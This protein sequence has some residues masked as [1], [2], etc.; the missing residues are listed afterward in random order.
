MVFAAALAPAVGLVAPNLGSGLLTFGA[1]TV[2]AVSS[3]FL[4]A[5]TDVNNFGFSATVSVH[6][7]TRSGTEEQTYLGSPYLTYTDTARIPQSVECSADLTSVSGDT[8]TG[9]ILCPVTNNDIGTGTA[10]I[11]FNGAS[12]LYGI[13]VGATST[14]LVETLT[15]TDAVPGQT[16]YLS[17]VTDTT[18]ETTT[19]TTKTITLRGDL[20]TSYCLASTTTTMTSPTTESTTKP[21]TRTTSTKSAP[22][23]TTSSKAAPTRTTSSKAAPT[24]TTSPKSPPATTSPPS[25]KCT[26]DNLYQT[27]ANHDGIAKHFCT[28]LLSEKHEGFPASIS[29]WPAATISSACS[30]YDKNIIGKR[31]TV[32]YDALTAYPVPAAS[33]SYV[34]TDTIIV[35]VDKIVSTSKAVVD[36]GTFTATASSTST[37]DLR[38]APTTCVPS[39]TLSKRTS[40]SS[41]SS[42]P[43]LK[44]QTAYLY[45]EMS[46]PVRFC[47]YYLSAKRTRSPLLSVNAKDLT[48]TCTCVVKD[49]GQHAT[50][51]QNDLANF[52]TEAASGCNQQYARAVNG[53]FRQSKN[54]CIYWGSNVSRGLTPIPGVSAAGIYSGCQ[55]I[56][57]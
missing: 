55:C 3:Y 4:A 53:F 50:S 15:T 5:S 19:T 41:L 36:G 12:P 46:E 39:P 43:S 30:C 51:Y 23:R 24:R 14:V 25:L 38:T 52:H 28:D 20:S 10:T 7:P 31:S 57:A 13:Y 44:L 42:C 29:V 16:E 2:V 37:V 48:D 35:S 27:L 11:A 26:K 45:L 56:L 1:G 34:S 54:F 47:N 40:P 18:Y 33:T 32:D 17:T 22:T 8:S 21:S 49:A 6:L 9:S